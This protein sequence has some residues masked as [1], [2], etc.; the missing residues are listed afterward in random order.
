M[1]AP[2]FVMAVAAVGQPYRM[3]HWERPIATD[4]SY[5]AG[6][7]DDVRRPGF[8]GRP[9]ISRPIMGSMQQGPYPVVS[10]SPGPE[11]YGAYNQ[12]DA[13]VYARVGLLAVGVNPWESISIGGLH[14]LEDARNFWLREQGFTGGVRT[15]VNDNTLWQTKAEPASDEHADAGAKA[16]GLPVPRAT[17]TLPADL[18]R[19][20]RRLRVDAGHAAPPMPPGDGPARVSWPDVKP[21]HNVVITQAQP[22]AGAEQPPAQT[23]AEAP[24]R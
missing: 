10:G 24:A 16:S 22:A 21:A 8:N 15:M 20:H 6:M 3:G 11:A 2:F 17:I 9:W 19:Q 18:P 23:V 13:T 14:R 5:P 1:I 12:P 4:A 7:A